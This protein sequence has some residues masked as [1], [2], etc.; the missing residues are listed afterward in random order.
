MTKAEIVR[1]VK[2]RTGLTR[3]QALNAVEIFLESIKDALKREERVCL[4][5]LGT[6]FVRHRRKRKGRNPKTGELI[7]VPEKKIPAFRAG[8]E[9]RNVVKQ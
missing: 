9:F 3:Q 5:G 2:A 1:L 6:F 8:R 7:S 4:V